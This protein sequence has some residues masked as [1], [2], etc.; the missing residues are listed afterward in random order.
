MANMTL[1]GLDSSGQIRVV[2][3]ADAL[4]DRA[5]NP[6]VLLTDLAQSGASAYQLV[7]RNSGNSAWVAVSNIT[8]PDGFYVTSPTVAGFKV[9][10]GDVSDTDQYGQLFLKGSLDGNFGLA[11]YP[12]DE[13]GTPVTFAHLGYS[14]NVERTFLGNASVKNAIG[15]DT[16]GDVHFF[17]HI[18]I[19][20][21]NIIKFGD[22]SEATIYLDSGDS[23]KLKFTGTIN[24]SGATTE[25]VS[26]TGLAAGGASALQVI[27]RNAG[28]TA[29]EIVDLVESGALRRSDIHVGEATSGNFDETAIQLAAT[30]NADS[31]VVVFVNGVQA[32]LADGVSEAQGSTAECYFAPTGDTDGST[33]VTIA[34][35][36]SSHYFYWKG[37]NA[38]Y[39]LDTSDRIKFTYM[40]Y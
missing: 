35:I 22:A 10:I 15:I 3:A 11:V 25:E 29:W 39:D 27:R 4:K 37:T 6:L 1:Y 32:I 21:D 7:Q 33:A 5:G 24:F 30:P 16:N 31:D 17:R 8:L 19:G 38:T 18:L 12:R 9:F 36:T 13:A 40:S 14:S 20:N 28:N 26:P 23:D 34:N 2:E